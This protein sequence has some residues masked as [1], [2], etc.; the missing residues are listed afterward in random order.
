[1]A[2]VP[3]HFSARIVDGLSTEATTVSYLLVPDTATL[4]LLTTALYSWTTDLDAITDG[5]ITHISML[6]TPALPG[7]LKTST[8][9]TTFV[10][11]R[12]EQTAVLNM[13]NT[14]NVRKFGQV[15]PAFSSSK[16]SAGKVNLGDTAVAAFLTLLQAA[17]AGGT[18][19]NQYNQALSALIDAII[20]FRKRRKQL[21]RTSFEV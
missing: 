17:V 7:G 1:M 19:V 4:T 12:V 21:Q 13:G 5:N 14:N 11:S 6:I 3:L 2:N 18:F 15:V 16:I 20:S 9:S 8:T 10:A